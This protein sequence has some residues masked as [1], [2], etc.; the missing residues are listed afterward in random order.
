MQILDGAGILDQLSL[1]K[2]S[3]Q[4]GQAKGHAR[5][6][7][8]AGRNG[9]GRI[10]GLGR[11]LNALS[12][13][14]RNEKAIQLLAVV[15]ESI[16]DTLAGG[17]LAKVQGLPVSLIL[18]TLGLK[19]S[20]ETILARPE[21]RVAV[22]HGVSTLGAGE[23]VVVVD[24]ILQRAHLGV[25]E[26]G[27]VGL[28]VVVEVNLDIG[29]LGLV[30]EAAGSTVVPVP[31]VGADEGLVVGNLGV[32]DDG[33]TSRLNE[34]DDAGQDLLL[35]GIGVNPEALPGETESGAL[36]GSAVGQELGV[37]AFGGQTLLG[38]SVV[39]SGVDAVDG[40]KSIGGIADSAAKGADGILVLGLG[41]DASARSQTNS[42]LNANNGIALSR[43]DD[44]TGFND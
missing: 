40:I 41:N 34:L 42:R 14:R 16:I 26:L 10:T 7:V 4:D 25:V 33:G 23:L 9:D 5:V 13:I 19:R 24:K 35:L 32:V 8:D 15:G 30:G 22:G 31:A 1:A 27:Q 12:D 36:E 44:Y 11:D 21:S 18:D 20:E 29:I 39:V 3:L 6:G 37:S 38:Q 28:D 2:S 43:V 17:G